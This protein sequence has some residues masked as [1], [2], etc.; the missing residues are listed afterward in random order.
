MTTSS[1]SL[2]SSDS[3][4]NESENES[5]FGSADW[6]DQQAP[7]DMKWRIWVRNEF[8]RWEPGHLLREHFEWLNE[9]W[10]FIDQR[11][12]SELGAIPVLWPIG[13]PFH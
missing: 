2:N 7:P 13:H 3:S 1:G 5:D 11:H 8:S 4:E 10:L 9:A 12:L 6:Y